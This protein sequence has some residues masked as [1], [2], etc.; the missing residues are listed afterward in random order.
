MNVCIIPARG[1]SKRIHKKNIK[2]F[3]GKPIVE[4]TY[5][6]VR[7]SGCFEQIL[8]SSDDS[9]IIQTAKGLGI[10]APF[11]RPLSLADD[12]TPTRAVI[13]HAINYLL[14][15]GYTLDYVCCVYPTACFIT[16]GDLVDS[17]KLLTSSDTSF[18]FSAAT[19]PYPIQRAF[20]ISSNGHCER[21]NPEHRFT[22]SQDLEDRYHDAGQ[23][24][25]GHYQAF[26]D[27]IDCVSSNG[28]PF[29]IPRERVHDIDTAEDWSLAERL[30]KATYQ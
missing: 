26:L 14:S 24:Y 16:A 20:R 30:F 21:L 2:L 9:E 1:G 19:Y 18:V 27:N 3:C 10:S 29:V 5:Q 11:V 23:F 15:C 6:Q 13:N 8:I 4:W 12:H 25:W 7:K 28:T 22:R 17:F